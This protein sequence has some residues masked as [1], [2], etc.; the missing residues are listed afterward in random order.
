MI[1]FSLNFDQENENLNKSN[2]ILFYATHRIVDAD[3]RNVAKN[4]IIIH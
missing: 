2:I 4:K 3:F 1:N